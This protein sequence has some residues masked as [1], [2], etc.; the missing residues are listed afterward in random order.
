MKYLNKYN[1]FDLIKE[2]LEEEKLKEFLPDLFDILMDLY[3][4]GKDVIIQ[5]SMYRFRLRSYMEDGSEEMKRDISLNFKPI[6][7]AGNKIRSNFK[8]N[9]AVGNLDYNKVNEITNDMVVINN[10]LSDLGWKM[11]D[12]KVE[13]VGSTFPGSIPQTIWLS[14]EF[15]KPSITIEGQHIPDENEVSDALY[16][17]GNLELQ[18]YSV[19]GNIV[20]IGADSPFTMDGKIESGDKEIKKMADVLGFSSFE[21]EITGESDWIRIKF[22]ID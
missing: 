10:R 21:Y 6:Y 12:F 11:V 9:V 4:S 7:K 22:W 3:D 19:D 5:S 15:E 17:I 18:E 8:I 13:K 1:N 20:Y 14:H 2:S 16:K